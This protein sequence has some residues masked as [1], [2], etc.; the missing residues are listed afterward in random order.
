MIE[1]TEE[2]PEPVTRTIFT[3]A[4]PDSSLM[5]AKVEGG[6]ATVTV[7]GTMQSIPL[8]ALTAYS[9]LIATVAASQVVVISEEEG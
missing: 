1:M 6:V 3:A 9:A 4:A 5:V 2:T 8:E 7:G